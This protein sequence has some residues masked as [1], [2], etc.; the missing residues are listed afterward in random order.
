MNGTSTTSRER[1]A[2][3]FAREYGYA[4]GLVFA[5]AALALGASKQ[6]MLE[7]ADL[8]R[9]WPRSTTIRAVANDAD[10][11]SES[12]G[13]TLMRPPLM[14]AGI[15]PIRLQHVFQFDGW[16][17]RVDAYAP[18]VDHIFEFDGW[19]KYDPALNGG[20]D[21]NT[22]LQREKRRE[23]WLRGM[24]MGLT[25]FEWYEVQ[26]DRWQLT[27]ARIRREVAE[28]SRPRRRPVYRPA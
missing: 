25:R 12:P 7:L 2:I 23:N 28:Q 1:T 14:L 5:D 10:G 11:G 22:V 3:D 13:E 24:G 20:I 27:V 9:H 21:P 16:S 4:S 18:L 17:A 19:M 15:G 8:T 26:P 6:R